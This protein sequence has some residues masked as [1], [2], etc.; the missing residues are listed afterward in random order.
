M[1]PLSGVVIIVGGLSVALGVYADLG[2]PLL[3][4]FAFF[5]RVLHARVL[6]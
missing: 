1:V 4:G 5:G 3:A 2:A 6:A